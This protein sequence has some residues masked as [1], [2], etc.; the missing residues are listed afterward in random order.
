MAAS[1]EGG[2]ASTAA[3][4]ANCL[5]F[6]MTRIGS[7]MRWRTKRFARATADTGCGRAEKSGLCVFAH[8]RLSAATAIRPCWRTAHSATL[9]ATHA[10]DQTHV[11][12][13]TSVLY[14]SA[15]GT[16]F[17]ADDISEAAQQKIAMYVME[18]T[19]VNA[20]ANV[21]FANI[22][23]PTTSLLAFAR[24]SSRAPTTTHTNA[25]RPTHCST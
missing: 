2:V 24:R 16:V 8:R 6:W 22:A 10:H 19:A 25:A 11:K 13:K 7:A 5:R 15:G 12:K 18:P 9:Q 21:R 17:L 3:I 23:S 4:L 1:A 20:M 14:C